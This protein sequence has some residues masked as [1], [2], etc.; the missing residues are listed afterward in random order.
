MN[1][2]IFCKIA[3]GE[4]PSEFLYE[5]DD[6]FAIKDISP[7]AP[8][9]ILIISK[10]HIPSILNITNNEAHLISKIH[11]LATHLATRY[12]LDED[13]FRIV[14]NCRKA[15]GQAV[16]HLHFHLLGGRQMQ[17]PPG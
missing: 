8:V 1:D 9:H 17:W 4:I 6:L 13:G 16:P 15:G 11:L 10:E 7:Q 3:A 12:K 14:N 5:D 2:C